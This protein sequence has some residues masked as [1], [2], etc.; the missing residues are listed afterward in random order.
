MSDINQSVNNIFTHLPTDLGT[1]VFEQ[2]VSGSS[3]RVERIVSKGHCTP[4]HDWY[5]QE[6]H[7]WVMV[8]KGQAKLEFADHSI[9]HLEAGSHINIPA[10]TR[11][12]VA[13][14]AP[15]TETLWLAVYY[16]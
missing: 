8:L 14:T 2:I 15:D 12:R 11:H 7:E 6:E 9:V 5:D 4:E 1:E 16:R 10:H 13:W 3:F